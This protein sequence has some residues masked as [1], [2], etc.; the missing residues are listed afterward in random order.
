MIE[1][2]TSSVRIIIRIDDIG[3]RVPVGWIVLRTETSNRRGG[4]YRWSRNQ[5]AT[6]I[7]TGV[8]S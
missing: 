8:R 7:S 6:Y 4:L 2:A 5:P 3:E 1:M